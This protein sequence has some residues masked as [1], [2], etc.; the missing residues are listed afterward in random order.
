MCGIPL[1][2]KTLVVVI[3]SFLQREKEPREISFFSIS[4]V[5]LPSSCFTPVIASWLR[6]LTSF[7]SALWWHLGLTHSDTCAVL[8]RLLSG[9]FGWG[10][11]FVV[12]RIAVINVPSPDPSCSLLPQHPPSSV[13]AA[14]DA[15]THGPGDSLL[16]VCVCVCVCVCLYAHVHVFV[17]LGGSNDVWEQWGGLF[18]LLNYQLIASYNFIVFPLFYRE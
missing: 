7:S 1:Q 8:L 2:K 4:L 6:V 11:L 16:C 13:P 5:F 3:K 14:P 12:D 17:C 10:P 15:W 18:R 9:A